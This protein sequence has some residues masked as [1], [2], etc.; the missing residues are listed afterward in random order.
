MYGS[1][2]KGK[3]V[4]LLELNN[5]LESMGLPR[6]AVND[7]KYRKQNE[8]GTY[9]TE[10][11]FP[12]DKFVMFPEGVLGEGLYGRTPT[13]LR[14]VLTG[15]VDVPFGNIYTTVYDTPDPVVTW[16]KAEGLFAPSFPAYKEVIMATV[17]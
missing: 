13:E 17:I 12:E 2:Q 8:D 6:I 9:T 5:L 10:R 16:T 4:S 3:F 14:R 7:A 1:V 15:H 11:F